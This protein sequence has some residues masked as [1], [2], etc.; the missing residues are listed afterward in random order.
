MRT[1][2]VL[3]GLLF[4]AL[5]FSACDKGSTTP[6]PGDND[7]GT[8]EVRFDETY[9]G[10][11]EGLSCPSGTVSTAC[12][13]PEAPSAD[14]AFATNRVGCSELATGG[15]GIV[16][17]F[18]DDYCDEAAEGGAPELG[19]FMPG[20][21]RTRGA[22]SMI[23]LYGVVDVFGNGGDADEILVEVYREGAD[24]ALGALIGMT[25]ASIDDANCAGSEDRIVNDM[26]QGVRR[27]GFYRIDDVPTETPL[28][29]KTS[30]AADFWK[31]LYTYNFEISNGEIETGAPSG[32]CAQIPATSRFRYKA[33]TLSRSDY[34]SI[35]LT[36]GVTGGIRAGHGAIAG[37]VHDCDNVRLEYAQVATR[38]T[39]VAFAY[40]NDNPENPLPVLGRTQGSSRLGLYAALDLEAGP[41]DIGAVGRVGGEL[42]SL[43]WYRAR[44]FPSA[45]T[46][47]T[48][49]GL[50]PEQTAAP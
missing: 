26:P 14:A 47:V 31:D 46:V 21:Y 11:C 33:R 3:S 16:R 5:S 25:T 13:C 15:S 29:I 23:T 18:E 39:P 43:G 41:V 34:N 6:P 22:P 44:V 17:T 2:P 28:I 35:P 12:T 4:G 36:A 50:R 37:E 38:P 20:M 19:C 48:L 9:G 1:I 8:R 45:V 27:L 10:T 24:G 49:R 32:A 7:A 30:G 42:V 40:F